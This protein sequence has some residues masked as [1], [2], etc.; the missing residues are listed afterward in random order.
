M[1][2]GA[3]AVDVEEVGQHEPEQGLV[4]RDLLPDLE[5]A[6]EGLLQHIPLL[7]HR[8]ALMHVAP[9][10][11]R[12]HQP[13]HGGDEER[14]LAGLH[15]G[16]VEQV[17]HHDEHHAHEERNGAAADV[18]QGEAVGG[19]HVH[20]LGG[21]HVRQ[22]AVV[23]HAGAI[24]A[25]GADDIEHQHD[26]PLRREAQG[27]GGGDAQQGKDGEQPL[28]P[29]RVIA[30]GAKDGRADGADE[31]GDAGGIAPPAAGDHI[32]LGQGGVEVGQDDG[33]DDG[34]EGGVGPVIHDPAPL[35]AGKSLEHRNG[36]LLY[37]AYAGC[38]HYSTGWCRCKRF[39]GDF[40]V[41]SAEK[42]RKAQTSGGNNLYAIVFL[43]MMCY[44]GAVLL[45]RL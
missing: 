44:N 26:L 2:D 43:L 1:D 8:V 24:E 20:T 7:G 11:N 15:G 25:D 10:G 17:G 14:D 34:G 38:F 41:C 40:S 37:T 28:L 9:H 29:A 36:S 4:L 30:Q 22:E 6:G 19:Y 3:H 5:D 33:G 45:H 21:G 16:D 31:G 32:A 18:A 13:P 39:H 23:E 27:G 35:H 42:H 12:E